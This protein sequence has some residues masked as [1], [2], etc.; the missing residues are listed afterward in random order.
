VRLGWTTS[1]DNSVSVT[2][3][4]IL[5]KPL[6]WLAQLESAE[7]CYAQ[8]H[9]RYRESLLLYEKVGDREGIASCLER[10]PELYLS[11]GQPSQGV[12]LWGAADALRRAIR[13]PM[14]LAARPGYE[15]AVARARAEQVNPPARA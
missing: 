4:M 11:M 8:A 14:F 15:Q 12:H 13:A 5:D 6:V 10:L 2:G 7:H 1:E 9:E 3:K